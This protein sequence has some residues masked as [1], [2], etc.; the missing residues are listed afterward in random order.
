MVALKVGKH[1]N[2]LGVT[3]TKEAAAHLRVKAGDT[4]YLTE[5]PGD[6][7]RITALDPNFE[8]QMSVAT[9]VMKRYRNAMREL[10]KR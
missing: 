5:A 4:L 2:S 1:G 6:G 3:L 9:G 8:H 10:A 7:Y